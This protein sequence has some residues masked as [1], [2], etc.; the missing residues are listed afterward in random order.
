MRSLHNAAGGALGRLL[1][2]VVAKLRAD[3]ADHLAFRGS[4]NRRL[5]GVYHT[6]DGEKTQIASALCAV[7]IGAQG[8][9]GLKRL[10]AIQSVFDGHQAVECLEG[11]AGQC[12]F[13]AVYHDMACAHVVL[14]AFVGLVN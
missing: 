2:Q 12:I 6:K 7:G 3:W 11:V 10:S 1:D 8:G 9:Q 4:V 13:S 14:H 5:K